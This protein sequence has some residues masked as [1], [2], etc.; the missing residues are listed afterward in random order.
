[1]TRHNNKSDM[2]VREIIEDVKDNICENYCKYTEQYRG[3]F[4]DPMEADE[5]KI[6]DMCHFCVMGRL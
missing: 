4:K 5:N 3:C 1:M 6:A 2:T